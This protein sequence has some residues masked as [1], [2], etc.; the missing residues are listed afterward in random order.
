MTS[1][2]LWE[3]KPPT[4]FISPFGIS[5]VAVGG[6]C[7]TGF[8]AA[9]HD[10]DEATFG[11]TLHEITASLPSGATPTPS[12]LARSTD[13]LRQQAGMNAAAASN[14]KRDVQM[15]RTQTKPD[16]QAAPG[17]DGTPPVHEKASAEI[18]RAEA[19]LP[20]MAASEPTCRTGGNGGNTISI[21]ERMA[22]NKAARSRVHANGAAQDL[23]EGGGA[24]LP[25][26]LKQSTAGKDG[27]G[28]LSRNFA[29]SSALSSLNRDLKTFGVSPQAICAARD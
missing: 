5:G 13:M 15:W 11:R 24:E 19:H 27:W 12:P 22:S 29:V 14:D 6:D 9:P 18:R 4:L 20:G 23:A 10:V 17:G 21:G 1:S 16:I 28:V 26:L 25:E 8:E 7:D 2:G 3:S